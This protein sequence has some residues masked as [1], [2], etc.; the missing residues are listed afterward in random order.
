MLH[1]AFMVLF[2]F[3]GHSLLHKS[4][5]DKQKVILSFFIAMGMMMMMMI[6]K[7]SEMFGLAKKRTKQDMQK[8]CCVMFVCSGMFKDK[9][10]F[11]TKS[12]PTSTPDT[13]NLD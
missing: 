4:N 13:F 5:E 8:V 3:F 6:E 2:G 11:E 12:L 7:I 10:T 9:H 1:I